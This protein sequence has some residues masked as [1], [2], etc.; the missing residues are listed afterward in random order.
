MYPE[1][2]LINKSN[3]NLV[4]FEAD[5]NNPHNEGFICFWEISNINSNQLIF[6]KRLTTEKAIK[7]WKLF[8]NEG[9]KK[10]E[11]KNKAA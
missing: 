4:V 2:A 5:I 9:W 10:T 8:M 7:Q 6:K 3:Q 1:G 11:E